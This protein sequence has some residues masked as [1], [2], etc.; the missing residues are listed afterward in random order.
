MTQLP[1]LT[2][3]YKSRSVIASAQRCLNLY[4]EVNGSETYGGLPQL[5]AAAQVTM[6]PTPGTTL[7]GSLSTPLQGPG[8]GAYTASNGTLYV[9]VANAVYMVTPLW[10][11][12]ILG[13]IQLG[14]NPVSMA[15]N[16]VTLILVDG[17]ESGYTIDL[18]ANVFG[19]LEDPTGSFTG[20][21]RVE[22]LD[23]FFIF[24]RPGT[25]IFYT[26][27][28]NSLTFDPRYFAAKV[29][30][31][32]LL[33]TLV[34]NQRNIWL[35]GEQT[36]EIW[37]DSGASD[38]PFAINPSNFIQHGCAAKY[39][40]A[41]WDAN[42]FWLAK[43]PQ[44]ILTVV[45]GTNYQTL[46][47]STY[48]I[49][50][51]FSV[52]PRVDDATGFTY[53]QLGHVFYVLTFPTADKTWVY[54]VGAE[55]WH[56]RAVSDAYGAE[57]R[58]RA[59]AFSFAYNKAVTLD[60]AN[61]SLIA[62]DPDVYTDLGLPIVRE[63]SFPH[64]VS[65]L[66]RIIFR[67]FVADM[68]TGDALVSTAYQNV[69]NPVIS[70]A[71][72]IAFTFPPAFG[73]SG[74]PITFN[75]TVYRGGDAVEVVFGSSPTIAPMSGWKKAEVSGSSWTISLAPEVPRAPV[76]QIA[77]INTA[78]TPVQTLSNVVESD[79]WA[80]FQ[81]NA[82]AGPPNWITQQ[83]G[84]KMYGALDAVADCYSFFGTV[85]NSISL[86]VVFSTHGEGD[87]IAQ[88][89][90]SAATLD[91]HSSGTIAPGTNASTISL[92]VSVPG[93]L[94]VSIVDQNNF[95][96]VSISSDITFDTSIVSTM[97]SGTEP[98]PT[99]ILLGT[100]I[101]EPGEVLITL[102]A[103][104]PGFSGSAGYLSVAL[105]SV[106]DPVTL[107]CWARKVGDP[108]IEVVTEVVITQ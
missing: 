21:D 100:E 55:L 28:A 27:L 40:I 52:Y 4:P 107:Y 34:V 61:G 24:N 64:L 73:V 50:N 10:Q 22:Y 102:S 95:V 9:C 96:P 31:S 11:Y 42:I 78:P 87:C 19:T 33:A 38:F 57:H 20:A 49:Q 13:Y 54:D 41:K 90:T 6:F 48:A 63:R 12:V 8:R 39:S 98:H 3:F 69:S 16:A 1:L 108:M 99:G 88:V 51:E 104:A 105:E 14:T 30:A 17:T 66:K 46:P 23:G 80:Y 32:D 2:G 37:Y 59:G 83:N 26:S 44:G 62:I 85:N 93:R 18:A 67:K 15:D 103:G 79:A 45:V 72:S 101:L 89:L 86:P 60:F 68:E 77:V 29:G 94:Y 25:Q 35:L 47:I 84:A 91:A 82:P 5:T 56:E 36:T 43:D 7:L 71:A 75:G 53:Q 58:I 92:D 76:S 65:E 70:G 106:Q 81:F 97:S 74:V